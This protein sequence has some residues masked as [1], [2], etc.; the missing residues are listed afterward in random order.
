MNVRAMHVLEITYDACFDVIVNTTV[1]FL[2]AEPLQLAITTLKF[3]TNNTH[4]GLQVFQ[5]FVWIG[6]AAFQ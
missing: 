1:E 5:C 3:Q 4:I 2:C 6:W